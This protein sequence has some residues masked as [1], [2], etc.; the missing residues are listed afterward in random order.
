MAGLA[1]KWVYLCNFC[2]ALIFSLALMPFSLWIVLLNGRY[3]SSTIM[4]LSPQPLAPIF[5]IYTMRLVKLHSP[6]PWLSYWI[7]PWLFR[8][9][10][11]PWLSHFSLMSSLRSCLYVFWLDWPYATTS[12]VI[13]THSY[14][15]T[16]PD[17]NL[18]PRQSLHSWPGCWSSLTGLS[19]NK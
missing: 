12:V 19:V 17:L 13:N 9:P 6:L 11:Y 5:S 15:S 8:F 4:S 10:L 3:G 18:F 2:I 1:I 7:Y 16:S 14:K